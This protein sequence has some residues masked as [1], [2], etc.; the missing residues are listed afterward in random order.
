[1][2]TGRSTYSMY[3]SSSTTS[4]PPTPPARRRNQ[5]NILFGTPASQLVSGTRAAWT[6]SQVTIFREWIGEKGPTKFLTCDLGPLLAR[7]NLD[8]YADVTNSVGEDVQGLL[9]E[10]VKRKLRAEKDNAIVRK[11][12]GGWQ[13]KEKKEEQKV[14]DSDSFKH[15]HEEA[16]RMPTEE[17]HHHVHHHHH[18]HTRNKRSESV[19]STADT[20]LTSASSATVTAS[21]N[22]SEAAERE[23][24]ASKK[25]GSGKVK[26]KDKRA[27]WDRAIVC[28]DSLKEA[29]L[30]MREVVEALPGD[31]SWLD[32]VSDD[33]ACKVGY[34][35]DSLWEYLEEEGFQ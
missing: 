13:K 26:D 7:L 16:R 30:H 8:G 19:D 11:K 15:Y 5:S 32:T 17:H 6:A 22:N 34:L 14:M 35:D 29:A 28:M 24:N 1:M 10:K 25:S 21:S 20:A 2:S 23:T 4:S 9:L 27:L 12:N 33:I 31:A 3:E 18:H